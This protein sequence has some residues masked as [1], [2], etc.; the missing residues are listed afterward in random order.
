MFKIN[1]RKLLFDKELNQSDLHRKTGIR[2]NTINAYY[3]GYVKRANIADLIKI[4]DV[5]ECSLSELMEYDPENK[6]NP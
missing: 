3:H 4:C 2:Y 6:N 1:L 5:L